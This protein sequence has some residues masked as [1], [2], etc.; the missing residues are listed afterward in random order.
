MNALQKLA[1]RAREHVGQMLERE[2]QWHEEP[3]DINY[4]RAKVVASML[5]DVQEAMSIEGRGEFANALLNM[6]KVLVF[7][8]QDSVNPRAQKK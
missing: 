8:M 4:I 1:E 2:Q 5:S 3:V 7:D 6:S